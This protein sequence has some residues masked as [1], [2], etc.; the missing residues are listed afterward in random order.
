MSARRSPLDRFRRAGLGA[1]LLLAWVLLATQAIG[2]VHAVLHAPRAALVDPGAT[3]DA[4]AVVFGHE[5]RGGDASPLCQLYD[6]LTH[7]DAAPALAIVLAPPPV[8]AADG[9]RLPPQLLRAAPRPVFAARAP[10]L[11]PSV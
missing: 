7:G 3:A 10:P 8:P 2:L 4:A 1:G 6:Q 5:A 9:L 11:P